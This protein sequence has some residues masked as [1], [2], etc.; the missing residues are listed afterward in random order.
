MTYNLTMM[1]A[2]S[3][4]YRWHSRLVVTTDNPPEERRFTAYAMLLM[5][6]DELQVP[7]NDDA[8]MRRFPSCCTA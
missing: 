5:V 1:L 4:K 8:V 7:P 3:C 2:F 6:V